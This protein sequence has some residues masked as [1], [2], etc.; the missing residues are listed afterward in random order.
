MI[1]DAETDDRNHAQQTQSD[2]RI[3]Y[4]HVPAL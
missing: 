3:R 1:P 4:V 2:P